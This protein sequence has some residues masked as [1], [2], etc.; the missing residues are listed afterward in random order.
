MIK[1]D[2]EQIANISDEEYKSFNE[3]WV[4]PYNAFFGQYDYIKVDYH[5]AAYEVERLVKDILETSLP[6]KDMNNLIAE[7]I[8]CEHHQVFKI[9]DSNVWAQQADNMLRNSLGVLAATCKE[10][11]IELF[12]YFSKVQAQ[13]K[14]GV[15][16]DEAQKIAD[17][18]I[19]SKWLALHFIAEFN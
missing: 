19:L 8:Y 11:H 7:I 1:A 16:C 14:P 3:R 18:G 6:E 15:Q 9:F 12:A 10:H 5:H 4:L 2:I 17:R 13:N